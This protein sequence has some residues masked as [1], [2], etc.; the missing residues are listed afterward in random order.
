MKAQEHLH[1]VNG[2][3]LSDPRLKLHVDDGRSFLKFSG[4]QYDLITADPI[5]PRISGVGVLYT[6]E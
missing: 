6:K 1:D 2:G 3:V 4:K 5:H